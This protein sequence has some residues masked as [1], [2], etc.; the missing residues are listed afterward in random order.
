MSTDPVDPTDATSPTGPDDPSD[1]TP[2][3][4]AAW[5]DAELDAI[6]TA[7]ELEIASLHSDGTTLGS[8]RTVWV[9]REGDD[10]YVRSVNGPGSDWYRASRVREAGRVTAGGVT[11]EVTFQT[12]ADPGLNDAIDEAYQRKYS[13]YAARVLAHITSDSAASTTIRLLPH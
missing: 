5:T 8:G 6:G 12:V 7:E 13:A 3:P 1:T 4:A 2:R 10:L 9:V 11:R